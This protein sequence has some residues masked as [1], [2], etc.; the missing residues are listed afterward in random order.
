L[1]LVGAPLK[2]DRFGATPPADLFQRFRTPEDLESGQVAPA[3]AAQEWR[4][5]LPARGVRPGGP[6]IDLLLWWDNSM[7][8]VLRPHVPEGV[9]LVAL[10]D[11][12]DMLLDWLAWGRRLPTRCRTRSRP[13]SGSRGCSNR[14]PSC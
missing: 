10:R 4:E 6:L 7:L 9:L 2:A 8:H 5:A 13:R 11:P 1:A 3:A 14:W 12:R